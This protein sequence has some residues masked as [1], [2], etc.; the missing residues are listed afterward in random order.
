ME[1]NLPCPIRPSVCVLGQPSPPT[2]ST[3]VCHVWRSVGSSFYSGRWVVASLVRPLRR[4]SLSQVSS[5]LQ[6]NPVQHTSKF[7]PL[8][9]R[10]IPLPSQ[11]PPPRPS[12]PPQ[13]L[14]HPP[15][16]LPAQ[17]SKSSHT[18]KFTLLT[19][20]LVPPPKT[21]PMPSSSSSRR[22]GS[23]RS[24]VRIGCRVVGVGL[25]MS[26]SQAQVQLSKNWAWGRRLTHTQWI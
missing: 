26:V 23:V 7:P 12:P 10:P 3:H 25:G 11:V 20:S 16:P 14:S 2:Q 19:T 18:S 6:S 21:H 9:T 22:V 17:P 13:H 1:R 15:S 5:T 8:T 4:R 24:T